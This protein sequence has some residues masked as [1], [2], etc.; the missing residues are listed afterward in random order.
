MFNAVK[1]YLEKG[2]EK[3]DADTERFLRQ[4]LENACVSKRFG[5]DAEE[6]RSLQEMLY[7]L[8]TTLSNSDM[9]KRVKKVGFDRMLGK[10]FDEALSKD[11]QER[12]EWE[13]IEEQLL[14]VVNT[15]TVF[16]WNF[17]LSV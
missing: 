8:Y 6:L 7:V 4:K 5:K 2:A 16:C 1:E 9:A 15:K 10:C 17:V 13:V 12:K 11:H 14:D 3:W